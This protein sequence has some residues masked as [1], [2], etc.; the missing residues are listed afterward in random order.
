MTEQIVELENRH[1]RNNLQFMGIKEKSGVESETWEESETK[2][3]VFLLEKMGLKTDEITI[4]RA[5]R[6]G[7]K[8]EKEGP[9]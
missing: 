8:R 7:K 5:H 4:E 3:K 1:Q 2:V 6:I 9:L